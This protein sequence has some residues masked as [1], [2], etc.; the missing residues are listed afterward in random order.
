MRLYDE[1]QKVIQNHCFIKGVFL[2][3][4]RF[5]DLWFN[6]AKFKSDKYIH[7]SKQLNIIPG[8]TYTYK[9]ILNSKKL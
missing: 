4:C 7:K 3:F 8:S 6:F 1:K 2:F 5:F 9:Y